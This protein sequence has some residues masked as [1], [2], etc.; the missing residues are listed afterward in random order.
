ME[1]SEEKTQG[2]GSRSPSMN[3]N[4]NDLESEYANN[5]SEYSMQLNNLYADQNTMGNNGNLAI[6]GD[7]I[8]NSNM[9]QSPHPNTSLLNNNNN[10]S[11]LRKLSNSSNKN[12]SKLNTMN[13]NKVLSAF[14]DDD[15][16]SS[17]SFSIHSNSVRSL[18]KSKTSYLSF[19]KNKHTNRK[20][21]IESVKSV[22]S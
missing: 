20:S 10:N 6:N 3:S 15:S 7:H 1:T 13:L 12:S 16:E 18:G 4:C 22:K 19:N 2:I 21:S 9:S 17:Q 8:I 14:N 5:F 11:Y